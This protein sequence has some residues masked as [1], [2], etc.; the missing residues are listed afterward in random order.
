MIEWFRNSEWNQEIEEIFEL[1]LKRA[2]GAFSK[3]QYLRI[4]ASYLLDTEKYGHVGEQLMKRLFKDYPE[5]SF[6]IRFGHEQL[7]DYYM[8]TKQFDLAEQEYE[9][10]VKYYHSDTRSGTTG[11]ADIKLADLILFTKQASKYEYAY[12]LITLDFENSGGDIGLNDSRYFYNL[13][14]ARLAKEL[15]ISVESKQFAK[16]ALE[17]SEVTE[18]QFSRH[19]TVGIVKAKEQEVKELKSIIAG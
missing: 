7:G 10:V 16:L 4:Q 8:R 9:E 11:L 19:K 1:K 13:T 3:A 2:R 5:E 17:L 18:P 14:R 12:K 6:S 15:G